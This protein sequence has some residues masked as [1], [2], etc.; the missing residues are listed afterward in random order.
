MI[1]GNLTL[2]I[3]MRCLVKSGSHRFASFVALLSVLGIAIGVAALITVATVMQSLQSRLS[4][5][6][7]SST[8]H[9]AVQ[10]GTDR[11]DSLL[12]L[13][14]VMAAAPFVAADAL[15]QTPK[16]MALISL[17]GL[18]YDALKLNAAGSANL[19]L[20]ELADEIPLKGSYELI[21]DSALFNRFGL[22]LDQ[23]VKLI[24]TINARYTPAGLT[25][26]QRNFTL[27]NYRPSLRDA[28]ILT[29]TG[30][31]ED[32]RRLF[33]MQESDIQVRLWLDD[34]QNADTVERELKAMGLS[35]SDWRETQGDFFRSVAMERLSMSVML[36]LIV[37]VAA[38]NILSALAMI[39][40]AR[41]KEIAVLKTLGM[42]P[43][44]ILKIFTAQGLLLGLTGAVSGTAL[45]IALSLN[46]NFILG[47]LGVP[48][49]N[50]LH[51]GLSPLS[52][53]MIA[54]TAVALSVICTIYPAVKAAGTDPV[55]NLV[56]L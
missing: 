29:A 36:F 53:L 38:F 2:S 17:Q 46:S 35:F 16:G 40:S 32:V 8:P 5:T 26:T 45:G 7:L 24:S 28:Q 1:S 21:A 14:H 22:M 11:I 48:A 42:S 3:A 51:I 56:K 34:P 15:M 54:L 30:N 31:L 47:L 44:A 39:V 4:G 13:P 43:R 55:K 41:L 9:V 20:R 33:R 10:C 19:E 23:K 37:I 18:S 49:G 27:V 25:P 12:A 52:I 6:V 50:A